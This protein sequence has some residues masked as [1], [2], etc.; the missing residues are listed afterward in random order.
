MEDTI[1][2]KLRQK[3]E[4]TEANFETT[5]EDQKEEEA[6]MSWEI[7]TDAAVAALLSESDGVTKHGTE[8]F[9]LWTTCFH[10]TSNR[11]RQNF[12]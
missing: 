3:Q 12:S 8:V 4:A 7:S 2:V 11:L 6:S 9:S 1:E 10:F 5:E